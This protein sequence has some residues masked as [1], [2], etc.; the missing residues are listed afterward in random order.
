MASIA[1]F[2]VSRIDSMVDE[3]I[4]AKFASANEANRAALQR[5]RGRAAIANARL[6][7]KAYKHIF[8]GARWNVLAKRG[9]RPQR[10]L[11]ASTGTKN[12]A[13]SDILYIETLIGPNTVN[14][15]PLETLDAYRD[16][17]KPA[18]TLETCLTESEC[19]LAGL[20]KA[21]IS[22]KAITDALT[23]DGV[24]KFEEAADKLYSAIAK[25][26]DALADTDRAHAAE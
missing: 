26:R 7:Y 1:S 4:D 2:F 17:G 23:E 20:E 22:L 10:L 8:S 19:I 5:A 14:T 9:A 3:Q 16:H 21:G 18:A 12:K 11:W 25:K 6:A 15:V 13:Y 24:K